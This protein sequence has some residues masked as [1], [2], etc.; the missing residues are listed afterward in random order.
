MESEPNQTNPGVWMD[1]HIHTDFSCD[2]QASMEAMCRGAISAG[3]AEIGFTEHF[4]LI[5]RDPCYAFF[6]AEAWWQ[7]LLECRE[8][9]DGHLA[10]KAGIEIGEP[11]RF[12]NEV[13][14]LLEE[15][16]WDFCLG[17]VHWVEDELIFDMDYY[18]QPPQ[19]A[20]R[21]YFRELLSMVQ[22]GRCD[23]V[24]HADIVKRYGFDRYGQ[25][26]PEVYENEIRDVL[27]ACAA[28]EIA[29]EINTST[30]RRPIQQPSPNKQ[31]VGWFFEEGGCH[32]TLGS[33]AHS[34]EEIAFG[35]DQV[36]GWLPDA[37]FNH[38]ASFTARQPHLVPLDGRRL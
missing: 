16:P 30:S 36:I 6:R 5:P 25:F 38:L 11:H 10:I 24:A 35:L 22:A 8:M 27:K 21:R 3:L 19:S 13:D 33:D 32:I 18:R 17:S 28:H 23:V 1:Y 26:R 29:L 9:F 20:Y 37:G 34:P 7:K 14:S 4:D 31:I 2:S 15:Y 12:V